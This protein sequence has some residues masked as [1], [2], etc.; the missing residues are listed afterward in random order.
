MGD[1]GGGGVEG[2]IGF[3]GVWMVGERLWEFGCGWCGWGVGCGGSGCLQ[4]GGGAGGGDGL[5][6]LSSS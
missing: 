5:V 6:V 1:G 4:S 3:A 2:W